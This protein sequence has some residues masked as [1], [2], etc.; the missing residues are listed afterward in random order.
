M[1]LEP[2]RTICENCLSDNICAGFQLMAPKAEVWICEDCCSDFTRK[3]QR[4]KKGLVVTT[5][6]SPQ[7]GVPKKR[8]SGGGGAAIGI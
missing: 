1:H 2:Y 8:R 3:I 5:S 7:K 6:E 4:K